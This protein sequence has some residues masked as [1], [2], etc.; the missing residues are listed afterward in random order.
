MRRDG[1]FSSSARRGEDFLDF[2]DSSV[3]DGI[4]R[5]EGKEEVERRGSEG[6]DEAKDLGE[7]DV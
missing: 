5:G 7:K 4:F 2:K 6:I 3:C 1:R